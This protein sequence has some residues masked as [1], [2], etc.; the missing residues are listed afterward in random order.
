MLAKLK[1]FEPSWMDLFTLAT[2]VKAKYT[3]KIYWKLK[4][5]QYMARTAFLFNSILERDHQNCFEI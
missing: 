5:L 1:L 4:L 3:H 2:I